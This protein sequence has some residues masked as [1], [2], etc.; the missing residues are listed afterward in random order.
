MLNPPGRTQVSRRTSP[1]LPNG[2]SVPSAG[3]GAPD[4]GGPS[5]GFP[6]GSG[7]VSTTAA[8]VPPE[9]SRGPQL[10]EQLDMLADVLAARRLADLERRGLF[11]RPEVF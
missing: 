7:P 4:R 9:Q 3:G 2:L 10:S 1:E 11:L 6:G 5:S 8:S